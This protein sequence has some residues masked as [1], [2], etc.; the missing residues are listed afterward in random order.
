[1]ASAPLMLCATASH[2]AF[3]RSS[4][5]STIT[6]LR[7]PTRPFSRRYP[8]KVE[9]IVCAL[10]SPALGPDVVDVG[11][12]PPRDRR[13]HAA[14]VHTVLD[15]GVADRHVPERHLVADGDVLRARQ[16]EGAVLV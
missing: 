14:D 9:F 1:M 15:H 12:L 8:R 6:W 2:A 13:D 3:D 16:R 5:G 4:T 7:T 11:V 10:P